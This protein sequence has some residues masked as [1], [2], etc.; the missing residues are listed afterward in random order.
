[1]IS[2]YNFSY[3]VFVSFRLIY[4]KIIGIEETV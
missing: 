2:K 3:C 1:M 4:D